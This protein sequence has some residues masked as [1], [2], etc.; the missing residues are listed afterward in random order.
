[1]G[2]VA[3]HVDLLLATGEHVLGR[4]V[5]RGAVQADVV[6]LERLD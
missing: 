5:A 6:G 3:L 4:D 1:M 2:L